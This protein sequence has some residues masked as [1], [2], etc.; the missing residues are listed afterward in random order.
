MVDDHKFPKEQDSAPAPEAKDAP[1][2][3]KQ[4]DE[5]PS[6]YQFDDWALI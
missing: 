2:Q 3:D 5:K 4:S 6:G 1:A